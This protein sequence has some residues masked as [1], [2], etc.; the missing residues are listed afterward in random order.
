[1]STLE[2]EKGVIFRIEN[3]EYTVG[4][5]QVDKI[6]E[7]QKITR[8]PNSPDYLKGVI[9]YQDRIIPVI[10]L[11]KRFGL[12]N[13]NIIDSTKIIIVKREDANVGILIDDVESIF[14]I[15]EGSL[16]PPPD[17][18]SGIVRDYIK[19]VIKLDK[20][21]IIYLDLGKILT[22]DEQKEINNLIG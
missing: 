3:E 18:I 11:K 20:R 14:T 5:D 2:E 4:I 21:V 6:L 13:T 9:K 22:F 15:E 16:C 17:I 7:F 1:M 10:D 8:I 19:G 12:D